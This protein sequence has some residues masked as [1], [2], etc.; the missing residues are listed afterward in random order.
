MRCNSCGTDNN[1]GQRFCRACGT[2]LENQVAQPQ[3]TQ[4]MQPG[5]NQSIQPQ[6]SQLM[7]PG[8]N[9][10]LQPQMTQSMQ[11][12]MNQSIQPQMT[13]SMQPGMNQNIQPQMN[14]GFQQPMNQP[15]YPTPNGMNQSIP[16][17]KKSGVG[18]IIGI[19]AG[20]V[21]GGFVFLYV[22]GSSVIN[23]DRLTGTFRCSESIYDDNRDIIVSFSNGKDFQM[24]D[25]TDKVTGTYSIIKEDFDSEDMIKTYQVT[26]QTNYTNLKGN[27]STEPVNVTYAIAVNEDGVA[28]MMNKETSTLLYCLK[29]S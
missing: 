11:L 20:I 29:D 10:S 8:M 27:E 6:M 22:L 23:E 26:I 2:P 15:T 24:H 21:V 19:I 25:S 1:N 7:Q 17:K 3:M 16:A 28:A 18:K 12:G 9:Q 4:S 5:M 14:P 13:Q